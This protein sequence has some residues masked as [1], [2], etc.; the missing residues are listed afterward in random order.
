MWDTEE[1]FESRL[2][3]LFAKEDQQGL[4][5][6]P[7]ADLNL[8]CNSFTVGQGTSVPPQ[9]RPSSQATLPRALP[10]GSL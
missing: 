3:P 10:E 1:R 4:G 7:G 5:G 9:S 2:L 6:D 8:P